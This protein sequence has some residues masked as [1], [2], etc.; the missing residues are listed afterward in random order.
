MGPRLQAE[1]DPEQLHRMLLNLMRNA[2]EAIE[3]T[4]DRGGVGVVKV[5]ASKADAVTVL[6]LADDGPGLSD[7]ARQRLFQ[8]FAGSSRSGGAGLGLAISR[9]LAQANG[10]DLDLVDSDAHGTTFEIRLPSGGPT[11]AEKDG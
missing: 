6:R 8:P 2:R 7:K 9:E 1:S 4:P 10:G 5:S 11:D 3:S